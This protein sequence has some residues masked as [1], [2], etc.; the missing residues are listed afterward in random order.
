MQQENNFDNEIAV[1][2]TTTADDDNDDALTNCDQNNKTLNNNNNTFENV[3]SIEIR[4]RASRKYFG[5]IDH[6]FYVINGSE[7]HVGN[8]KK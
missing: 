8:Y 2:G 7:Y 6:Y 4:C 1:V 3:K 5:L